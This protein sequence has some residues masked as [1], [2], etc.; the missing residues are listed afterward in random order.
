MKSDLFAGQASEP[1]Y[2][3]SVQTKTDLSEILPFWATYQDYYLTFE[4]GTWKVF[5]IF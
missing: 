3:L 4:G 2:L 5:A 1:Q